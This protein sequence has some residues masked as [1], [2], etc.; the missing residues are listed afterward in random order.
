MK[1]FILIIALICLIFIPGILA[2]QEITA[3]TENAAV[4][5]AYQGPSAGMV[6]LDL[7]LVRPAC[8][9]GALISTAVCIVTMPGAFLTGVGEQS[10]RLL[11][12]APWRFTTARPLGEFTTYRDDRPITHV[13]R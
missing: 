12:E 4:Q 8:L 9:V 11:V 3:N 6:V 10:A 2:A 13:E 5:P 1:R 7:L